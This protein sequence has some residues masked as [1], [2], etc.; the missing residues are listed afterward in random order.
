[1]SI[2]FSSL[3]VVDS[4]VDPAFYGFIDSYLWMRASVSATNELSTPCPVF[5][6]PSNIEMPVLLEK[7]MISCSDTSLF[8][9]MS[10]LSGL[11]SLLELPSP[12]VVSLEPADLS[13]RSSLLAMTMIYIFG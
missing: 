1:L 6:D 4:Y 5:A 13:R 12:G 8:G 9:T 2:G 11:S 10:S 3:L 7:S